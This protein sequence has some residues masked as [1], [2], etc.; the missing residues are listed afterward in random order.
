MKSYYK[1]CYKICLAQKI[2]YKYPVFSRES[3][4]GSF[5]Q[6]KMYEMIKSLTGQMNQLEH[7]MGVLAI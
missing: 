4:Y 3:D 2:T 6:P 7:I 1:C 5:F